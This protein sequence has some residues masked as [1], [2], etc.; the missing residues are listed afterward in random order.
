MRN[1]VVAALLVVAILAGAG[2]GYYIGNSSEH[3]TTSVSTTTLAAT[4]NQTAST[5]TGLPTYQLSIL[6]ANWTL[7]YADAGSCYVSYPSSIT[8][9][10][11]GSCGIESGR[12]VTGNGVFHAGPPVTDGTFPVGP[13]ESGY[14]NL[15]VKNIGSNAYLVFDVVTSAPY[16][17]FFANSQGCQDFTAVGFCGYAGANSNT[18]F[19]FTF[20]SV[21]G[22]YKPMNVTLSIG[23]AVVPYSSL[24]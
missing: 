11:F 4:S 20:L 3:T 18:K 15:T 17:V 13:S 21:P 10:Q 1:G 5:T 16:G 19:S 2:A 22:D 6:S 8:F 9:T 24:G 14:V 12:F 7:P 23:V